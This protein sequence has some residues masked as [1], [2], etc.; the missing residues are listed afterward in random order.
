ML[1]SDPAFRKRHTRQHLN[2]VSAHKKIFGLNVT[3]CPLVRYNNFYV[4]AQPCH[5]TLG[6]RITPETMGG[7]TMFADTLNTYSSSTLPLLEEDLAQQMLQIVEYGTKAEQVP[8]ERLNGQAELVKNRAQAAQLAANILA[9]S[10]MRLGMKHVKLY[11]SDLKSEDHRMD[12]AQTCFEALHYAAFKYDLRHPKGAKY[13]TYAMYQVRQKT[14]VEF[15]KIREKMKSNESILSLDQPFS[16]GGADSSFN[17]LDVVEDEESLGKFG[18][19]E[20]EMDISMFLKKL[21]GREREALSLYYGV[22]DGAHEEDKRSYQ[23]VGDIMAVSSET[24]R[25]TVLEAKLRL[26]NF[27]KVVDGGFSS[28]PDWD[29]LDLDFEVPEVLIDQVLP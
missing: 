29:D 21:P 12:L 9:Q 2:A 5:K 16:D 27:L 11:L 15:K 19:S 20:N 4:E 6:G 14:N 3:A 1:G 22:G 17:L 10:N 25:E 24:A 26:A 18:T 7:E 8:A 28:A 13:Q 23:Q